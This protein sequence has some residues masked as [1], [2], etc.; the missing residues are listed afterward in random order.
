MLKDHIDKYYMEGNYN[1]A[2]TVIRAGNDYYDLGLHDHDM[3]SYGV[4]GAGIQTG[5]TCGAVIAAAAILSMKY[6]E[7]K[8][9]ES[10]DIKPVTLKLIRAFN[11]RYGSILCKDIKAQSFDREV[12]CRKT[13]ETACDILES[14]IAEYDSEKAG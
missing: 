4:F 1:C 10:E 6:V 8:A 14:V 2:E 7:K 9:H 3:I 5:N 11:E 13:V 12:R